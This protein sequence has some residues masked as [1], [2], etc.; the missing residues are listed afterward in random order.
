MKEK[1]KLEKRLLLN[2]YYMFIYTYVT[3]CNVTWGRAP[4]V[5]L[6]IKLQKRIVRIISHVGLSDQAEVLFTSLQ[7]VNM[8]KI[9][10]YHLY[11]ILMFEHN[12]GI[13]PTFNDLLV[14]ST[15]THKYSTKQKLAYKIPFCRTN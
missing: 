4:K 2:L 9:N 14:L 7:I 5:Y 8:Y 13:L 6:E 12:K 3:Y 10:S 11:C 1:N 15:M